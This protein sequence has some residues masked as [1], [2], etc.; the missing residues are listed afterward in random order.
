MDKNLKA[1]S[2]FS[3]CG[4]ADLGLIGGFTYLGKKYK[5]NPISIVHA[6]DIDHKAVDTYNKN[7]KHHAVVDD[8]HNLDFRDINADIVIGGFPCQNF[9]TVN[10]TKIPEKK[11]NQLFWQ[12]GKVV[13][14]IKPKILIA[15][16]VKG[17]FTLKNNFYYDLAKK[18]FENSGYNIS[19]FI[20]NATHY[21]IPQ[22][23]QRLIMVG[24]R[25]DLSVKT[26]EKPP[27]VISDEK[28]WIPL[29][30]VIKSLIPEDDKYY[31]SKKAIEGV[32][33]AKNN[34]K[35]AVVQDMNGPCLTITSHLAKVSI[36]SRDPVLLVNPQKEMYR[37]FTTREAARIQSFPENFIF[38]GSEGDAYRQIGNAVPPVLMWHVTN[39]ILNILKKNSNDF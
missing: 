35:R 31:F 34:M 7:F 4:G 33:K 3:G 20:L 17:F 28:Q 19:S 16:N 15:E 29:K 11:S 8:V 36:N 30:K 1:I 24:L 27:Y 2:L 21:G 22:K 14:E 10:P 18:E 13:S 38:T 5:K 6:S 25:D 12:M 23:R 39:H 9:S 32:K 26:I 37:R